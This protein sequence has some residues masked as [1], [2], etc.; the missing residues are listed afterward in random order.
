[1]SVRQGREVLALPG[2][3]PVPDEVLAA[4]HRPA[5]DIYAGEAIALTD[6]LLADLRRVFG[7][8]GRTY[9]YAANG[10]GAWEAAITNVL[11]QGDLVLV[12]ESGRFA[13]NWGNQAKMRGADVEI[14]PGDLRH[15]VDPAAVEA[16]LKADSEGRIRAILVVHVDTAT[17]VVNDIPAIRQA[18]DAAGHD[19]L[20]LVDAIAS[21]ATMPFDMDG[22]GVDVTVS[23]S[24]KGLM[25]PPGL[26]FNAVGPRALEAH[27]TAGLRSSYWDW[28]AREGELHYEKY[29]G[30]PP[31]HLLFGLRRALDLLFEEG[32]EAA[33]ARHRLLAGTV[34]AA[35]DQWVTGQALAYNIIEPAARSDS[36]TTIRMD[37][38][39]GFPGPGPLVD[40]CREQCG[41]I[42][43]IGIGALRG[44]AFRIA[45]MGHVNAPAILGILGVVETGLRTLG[46]PHGEGGVQAAIARL[47]EGLP[48]ASPASG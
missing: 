15:P 47:S 28:T 27:K 13:I 17:G 23:A 5:I 42:L 3:T 16:R 26:S 44:Q 9:I 43:G 1:M 32:L 38:S 21:L 25:T 29:S 45:H 18:I 22:W 46:I 40:W 4:M 36:V 19:A 10:H 33:W 12:L 39:G 24:Q 35:V 48:G 11:S 2:P 20:L 7:T 14:L 37:G 8:E 34:R 6:S 30:T 31:E 41:L